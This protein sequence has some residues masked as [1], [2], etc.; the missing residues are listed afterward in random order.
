MLWS[1]INSEIKSVLYCLTNCK[2]EEVREFLKTLLNPQL[3][4]SMIVWYVV[5][6]SV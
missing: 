5:L 6:C 3:T 2:P 1:V 4:R